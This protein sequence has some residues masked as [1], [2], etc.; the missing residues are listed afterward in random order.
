VGAG[1]RAGA[2]FGPD[3]RRSQHNPGVASGTG[4]DTRSSSPAT[5]RFTARRLKSAF[6]LWRGSV[7]RTD[8]LIAGIVSALSLGIAAYVYA[9]ALAAARFEFAKQQSLQ[10]AITKSLNDLLRT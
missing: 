7:R 3:G 4:A 9:R 8:F 6:G 5:S 10:A 1:S 2:I